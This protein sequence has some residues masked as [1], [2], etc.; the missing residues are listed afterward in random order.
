MYT[1]LYQMPIKKNRKITTLQKFGKEYSISFEVKATKFI[2]TWASVIHFTKGGNIANYGDRAP[3]VWFRPGGSRFH[4]CSAVNGQSNYCR[5]PTKPFKT[6]VW[7]SVTIT[8]F[9]S[10]SVYLYQIFINNEMIHST[11]NRQ[12]QDFK[13]VMVYVGEPWY[14]PQPGFIRNLVIRGKNG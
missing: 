4:I 10:G 6:G 7:I 2:R 9:K 14:N 3:A 11:T 8:Q 1:Y 5:N 13:N 12:P